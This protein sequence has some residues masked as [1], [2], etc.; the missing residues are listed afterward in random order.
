MTEVGT[1]ARSDESRPLLEIK[2][3]RISFPVGKEV[4]RAVN[5]ISLALETG[6]SLGVVGES[7]CGKSVTFNGVMRLLKSPPAAIEGEVFLNG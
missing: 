3:M 4:V 1:A 2:N 7:G 6:E 5:G